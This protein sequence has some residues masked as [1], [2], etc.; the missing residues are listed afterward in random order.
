M[1]HGILPT[2]LPFAQHKSAFYPG[3]QALKLTPNLTGQSKLAI[4]H[5]Q[6]A[7][8]TDEDGSL[9]YQLARACAA[10]GQSQLSRRM[11]RQCQAMHEASASARMSEEE[12]SP[13]T[14]AIP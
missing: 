7:L 12:E 2:D 11:M 4:P 6:L 5:L 10:E 9:H 14:A 13:I 3:R 8:P 1:A